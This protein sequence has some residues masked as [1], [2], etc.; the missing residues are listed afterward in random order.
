M[1]LA[2]EV[3]TRTWPARLVGLLHRRAVWLIAALLAVTLGLGAYAARIGIDNSLEVWFVDGDP[4]LAAYDDY[5]ATF[6][7]D[8]AIVIAVTAPDGIYTPAYLE[9]IRAA[10]D[11][12]EALPRVRRVQSLATSLHATDEDGEIVVGPLA[13][14]VG[15]ITDADAEAVRR[16]I[17]ADP[18]FEGLLVNDGDQVSVILVEPRDTPD[19]EK[20]RKA[21]IDDVAKIAHAELERDGS[22][23]HLGGIGVVYQGLNDASMR[24]TSLF[25]TLSYLVLLLGLWVIF[26]RVVWVLVGGA[27]VSVSVLATLGVAGLAGRDLNMVTGVI[28][29]LIMT[30]GILDL[31]H[32]V[33]AYEEGAALG[34]SRD[35]ILRTTVAVTIVP[36]IVNSLTDVLGFA[37]FVGAPVG[38]IRDLGWL[39]SIG[40]VILLAAVLVIGVPA[41]ARFGGRRSAKAIEHD[42]G[43]VTRAVLWLLDVAIRRRA[44]VL[45]TAA[46]LFGLS[47]WGMSRLTVD[48]YTIG[49]LPEDH[50]VRRD[51][52]AIER[53]FGSYVPLE[54]TV[55]ARGDAQINDPE[56]LAAIERTQ[57]GFA[58]D[59]RIGGV[60]GMPDIVLQS[61]AVFTGKRELPDSRAGVVQIAD[62]VYG[63]SKEGRDH[64][65]HLLDVPDAPKRTHVT[66]R[67][68]LPSANAISRLLHDLD[69]R[70]AAEDR[71][72][73]VK[74]AGYLPLYVR[75]TQHI[76]DAQIQSA[77]SAF[78]L[79]TLVMILLL[80][81]VK[82]GIVAMVPNLLPAV[83][84][85]GMM[86][87]VGIPLDLATVLIAGIAIGISV[88]DTSHIMFRYRHELA[89]S[90]GDPPGALRRMMLGTG[91]PVVM[92][93]LTLIAGFAV[94]LG[95][96]VKSV[97]YFGLLTVVTTACALLADLLVTPAL[98]L[99]VSGGARARR[100]AAAGSAPARG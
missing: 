47:V 26:R 3:D 99:A 94:L 61:M 85:L 23:V 24:D 27:I 29:T 96:S 45:A 28:P 22:E 78:L 6:G 63:Q 97:Y 30:I 57:R 38:A 36:C 84:T 66:A 89:L 92:S 86:G 76:T 71:V 15:P 54:M 51:H 77:L 16:R 44:A 7:N 98:I 12:L 95:A 40:L 14:A 17:A 93:S 49:F 43:L 11:Q 33:D 2:P 75:I 91:R 82:L 25:V 87:F 9:R 72:I 80:R 100:A 73:D 37:S 31:V 55:D 53:E 20:A 90:P 58:D 65:D 50:P 83:M 48:T 39:V 34:L 74:P 42:R 18:R 64:L 56:V 62:A 88:N 79:V 69:Q 60:S 8:E 41:L 13:P 21:L 67:S 52:E 4:A 68:G 1:S 5:K 35:R 19:F 46:V 70:A 10:A 32:L 59:P 81:S